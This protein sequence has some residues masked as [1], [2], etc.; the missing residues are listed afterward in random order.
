MPV[1]ECFLCAENLEV[2][3]LDNGGEP[4]LMGF[5]ATRWVKAFDPEAAELKAVQM[6]RDE[7]RSKLTQQCDLSLNKVA[8]I[9]LE[10]ISVVRRK[11]WRRKN[12][13]AAWFPMEE[14]I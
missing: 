3:D 5:Y 2:D 10:E 6:L 12:R 1:Y 8:K 13:G 7:Y 11:P 14:D 4:K 9:H